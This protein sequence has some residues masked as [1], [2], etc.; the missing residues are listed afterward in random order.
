M[1]DL[2]LNPRPTPALPSQNA[3]A[4]YPDYKD[5]SLYSQPSQPSPAPA[6]APK[7]PVDHSGLMDAMTQQLQTSRELL[8]TMNSL[9]NFLQNRMMTE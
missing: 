7:C 1:I 4:P 2:K 6:P 5:Y 9:L 8:T 3:F